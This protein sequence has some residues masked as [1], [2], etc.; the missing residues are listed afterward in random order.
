MARVYDVDKGMLERTQKYLMNQRDGQG[1]FKRNPR[2]LD[3]FGRAPQDVTDAYIV[4]ALTESG[5]DDDVTREL[6]ALAEKAKASKDPYFL[7]LVANSLIN[8]ARTADA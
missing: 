1:G 3:S 2:A 4:W 5:K 8:R 7:A 6:N